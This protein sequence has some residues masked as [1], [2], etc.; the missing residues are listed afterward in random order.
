MIFRQLNKTLSIK[1]KA[2]KVNNV[3]LCSRAV[4]ARTTGMSEITEQEAAS[5]S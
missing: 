3:T 5:V 4:L 1:M 2:P